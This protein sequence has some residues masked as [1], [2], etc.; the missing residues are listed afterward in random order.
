MSLWKIYDLGPGHH[1]R[2]LNEGRT[3]LERYFCA[4]VEAT[5]RHWTPEFNMTMEVAHRVV[6]WKNAWEDA[7]IKLSAGRPE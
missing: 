3:R 7:R 5:A 2:L 1:G 4:G 6:R